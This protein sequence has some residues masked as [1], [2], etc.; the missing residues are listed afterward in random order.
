MTKLT[1]IAAALLTLLLAFS[2]TASANNDGPE[3]HRLEITSD[4]GS[5]GLYNYNEKVIVTAVFD[6]IVTIDTDDN[7]EVVLLTYDDPVHG[8]RY[9]P[10]LYHEGSGTNIITFRRTASDAPYAGA[11]RISGGAFDVYWD[12]D[13]YEIDYPAFNPGDDVLI[14]DMP[15]IRYVRFA[16]SPRSGDEYGAREF[17]M[18]DVE[19]DR[20]VYLDIPDLSGWGNSGSLQDWPTI[21]M[22]LNSGDGEA[23]Y[24]SGNGTNTLRFLYGVVSGDYDPDGAGV[25]A[26]TLKV[27]LNEAK[28]DDKMHYAFLPQKRSCDNHKIDAR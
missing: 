28:D 26:Q 6:R 2:A 22:A 16:S 4:G 17:I 23:V 9:L 18:V 27:Y 19:F 13:E 7:V 11:Y 10:A 12:D 20:A 14:N 15:E 5:D 25:R 1:I 21:T 8:E 3:L 24:S